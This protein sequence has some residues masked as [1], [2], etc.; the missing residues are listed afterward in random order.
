M[1]R[2][3]DVSWV[4][5]LEAKGQTFRNRAGKTED[6]LQVLKDEGMDSVRLRVWVNPARP[7]SGKEDVVKKALRV[8]AAGMRLMI[9]FHYSDYWADPGKQRKP[10]AWENHSVAQLAEDVRQH[11]GDILAA[12]KT[13]GVEPEWVQVGNETNNGMLWPEGRAQTNLANYAAFQTSGYEGVKA[14]F[15]NAIVVLHLANGWDL[16]TYR[17]MLDGLAQYHAK[18]DVVG[19]SLYPKASDWQQPDD[20]CFDT[21]REVEARYGKRVIVAEIGMDWHEEQ[22][23]GDFIRDILAKTEAAHGLGVFYWEP[24]TI[25]AETGYQ[26]GAFTADGRPTAA[27]LSRRRAMGPVACT[28]T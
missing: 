4:T 7:W 9:D 22:A 19:M 28:S 21:M 27:R 11:T 3:A 26:K 14:V 10:A 8:K 5:E 16:R 6:L 13:A 15:P 1:A 24:E 20:D 25:G 23:G 17:W 12:L 18:Y 2:G